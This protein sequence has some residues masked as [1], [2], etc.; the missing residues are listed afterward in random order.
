[1]RPLAC[2]STYAIP[3]GHYSA[4]FSNVVALMLKPILLVEDSSF[5]LELILVSLE[6]S[7][8]ANEVVVARDGEEAL[9]YLLRRNAF[10]SRPEGNPAVVLL[11][12][13]LPKLNGLEVLEVI[14]SIDELRTIPVAMLTGSKME[15]D[16]E[17]AY[18]VRGE[19]LRRQTARV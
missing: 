3:Q 12:L 10:A 18:W 16:V 15:C 9:D 7:K 13:K 1:M 6:R 11:D 14:R 5:D 8:L 2:L 4:R 19:C 17:K